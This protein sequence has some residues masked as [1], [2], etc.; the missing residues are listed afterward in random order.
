MNSAVDAKGYSLIDVQL[1]IVREDVTE[2][3]LGPM[4]KRLTTLESAQFE[5]DRYRTL[6]SHYPK[7]TRLTN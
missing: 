3:G 1:E 7:K 5:G 4:R 6:S 2:G